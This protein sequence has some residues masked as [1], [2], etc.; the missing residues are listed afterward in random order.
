MRQR[1]QRNY[2]QEQRTATMAAWS[3]SSGE[4]TFLDEE[5]A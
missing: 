5:D 4:E 3:N 1:A 2:Y